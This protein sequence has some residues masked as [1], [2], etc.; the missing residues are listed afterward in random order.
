MRDLGRLLLL[1]CGLYLWWICRRRG[2]SLTV[3]RNYKGETGEGSGVCWHE[4]LK[5]LLDI[6]TL[7]GVN[8]RRGRRS[9]GVF[10][11]RFRILSTHPLSV[12]SGGTWVGKRGEHYPGQTT[13]P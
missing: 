3:L 7:P 6:T 9:L 1:G 10:R 2:S 13:L 11:F 4:P 12:P 5:P 8:R